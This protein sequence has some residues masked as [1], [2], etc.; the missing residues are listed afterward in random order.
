MSEHEFQDSKAPMVTQAGIGPRPR[1]DASRPALQAQAVDQV[2]CS[3]GDA[4]CAGAHASSLRRST[5]TGRT[6]L[7]RSLLTLQ[8]QYG[9]QYVGQVLNRAGASDEHVETDPGAIGREIETARGGGNG[10]DA[11]VRDQMQSSFG[12]DF[13]GVRVH[14]DMRADGLSRALEARAFTTGKDIF[15]RQGEYE[16]G[17]SNGRAL[18]AHELTHVVQQ[19]GDAVSRQMTV[20]QPGDPEEVEAEQMARAVMLQEQ[21]GP[22]RQAS[23]SPSRDTG[24]QR[25]PEAV[26]EDEDKEKRKRLS[27]QA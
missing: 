7:E 22:S 21:A 14:T 1:A 6:S 24:L 8:R 15:F 4:A 18:L 17:S 10:L 12:A 3:L 27:G 25:Q 16:P 13:S 11:P 19:N 5:L 23:Q 20:S 2:T 9:N 26:A